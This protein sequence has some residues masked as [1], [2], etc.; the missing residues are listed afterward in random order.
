MEKTLEENVES[1]RRV[2]CALNL[3]NIFLAAF[4]SALLL[5][6]V[7]VCFMKAWRDPVLLTGVGIFACLLFPFNL[8]GAFAFAQKGQWTVRPEGLAAPG[9]YPTII[10]WD[11]I[12]SCKKTLGDLCLYLNDENDVSR[13]PADMGKWRRRFNEFALRSMRP[14]RLTWSPFIRNSAAMAEAVSR[15]APEDNALRKA[16][17]R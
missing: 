16:L 2:A 7:F 12:W 1:G 4:L 10:E 11:R 3:R 5:G 15:Y 6:A 14:I 17:R 8:L 13:L 9:V